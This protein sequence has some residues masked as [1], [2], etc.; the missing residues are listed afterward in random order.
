MP[1]SLSARPSIFRRTKILRHKESDRLAG[2]RELIKTSEG[3]ETL[4]VRPGSV[5]PFRFDP[6]DDHR[7]A[8]S[9]AVL[10]RLHDVKLTLRGMNCVAKSF[11]AFWT[12]AA[13]SGLEVEEWR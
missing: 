2:I 9:A 12:E 1:K 3:D 10:A 7:L 8:M 6:H 5:S 13:E 4:T 11:P